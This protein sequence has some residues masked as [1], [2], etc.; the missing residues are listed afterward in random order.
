MLESQ[1]D[2]QSWLNKSLPPLN[3]SWEVLL[4]G[5]IILA[6][7]ISRF[8]DLGTRVMS[9]DESLHTYYSWL[10]FK[11][12]GFSHTPLM[13]GPLQFHLLA[14][15]YQLFG[16]SDFSARIPAALFSIATVAFIW[17]FR[18][19]LG[20][21][22]AL[23]TAFLF[24]IS[25]YMLYYGRYARN[26]SFVVLFG[27]VSFW[28]IL[29]YIDTGKY[30]YLY[31]L[32][33]STALH[34][35]A[36]ETS[37]IYVAQTLIFLGFLFLHQVN[38]GK[39]KHD[40]DRTLFIVTLIL[41]LVLI[42]SAF[43]IGLSQRS[44]I[45]LNPDEIAAPAVPDETDLE[46]A[47][48]LTSSPLILGLGLLAFI[49]LIAAFVFLFKGYGADWLKNTRSFEI[50]IL[51]FGLVIPHL[52]A[53]PVRLAGWDPLDYTTTAT[54]ILFGNEITYLQAITQIGTFL[55]PLLILSFAIGLWW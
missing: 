27:L 5:L 12:S 21:T 19:Y 48:S 29:R 55:L 7:I 23:I 44:D 13:H 49:S 11:G 8:Y 26:E 17:K 2:K 38:L 15:A 35:T 28:A 33:A 53:F 10:L 1:D 46:E 34:F 36:K 32:T 51:L 4:F 52:A 9:H 6:A 37:F 42:G 41:A 18:R 39:W 54:N 3:I 24:V 20:K 22:G 40:S 45:A 16:D 30:H 25:P 43:G 31:Y 14:F 47:P 50:I